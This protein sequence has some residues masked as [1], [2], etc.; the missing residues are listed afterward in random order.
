MRSFQHGAPEA[1][2]DRV[3]HRVQKP[4]ELVGRRFL[5]GARIAAQPM[6]AFLDEQFG[7]TAS[8]VDDNVKILRSGLGDFPGVVR[9]RWMGDCYVAGL[10]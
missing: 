7:F 8:T 5:T 4:P 9:I 1:M 3:G 2:L 10:E 6:L